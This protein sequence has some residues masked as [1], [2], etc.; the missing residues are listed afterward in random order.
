MNDKFMQLKETQRE[1]PDQPCHPAEYSW[2]M[3]C[4]DLGYELRCPHCRRWHPVVKKYENGTDYT[5]QM[6]MWECRGG[7]YY[8][9][10]IGGESRFPTRPRAV[11]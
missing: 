5:T 9:G 8:A 2:A 11:R 1:P 10:Q 3:N 7:F 6:L 4:V